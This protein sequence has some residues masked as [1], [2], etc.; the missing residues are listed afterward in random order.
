[1]KY[2]FIIINYYT[3]EHLLFRLNNKNFH[4]IVALMQ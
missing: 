2:I 1:M 4:Y 3:L